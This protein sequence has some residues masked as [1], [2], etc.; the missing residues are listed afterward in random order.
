MG[1]SAQ[2]GSTRSTAR[3]FEPSSGTA[4]RRSSARD[5]GRCGCPKTT[6]ALLGLRGKLAERCTRPAS[7]S[8]SAT[9][10]FMQT[11]YL[12]QI[13]RGQQIAIQ[14]PNLLASLNL[15]EIRIPFVG[16]AWR[17][18]VR[19]RTSSTACRLPDYAPSAHRHAG[20]SPPPPSARSVPPGRIPLQGPI[21]TD[22]PAVSKIPGSSST[23]AKKRKN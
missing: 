17:A 20:C 15:L 7:P 6:H 19:N 21:R 22:H 3:T 5:R 1:L 8:V 10:R 14:N 18:N 4:T 9:D 23:R 11:I 16:F 2:G 13:R 12:Q